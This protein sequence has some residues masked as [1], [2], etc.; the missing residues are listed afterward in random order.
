[1]AS[2]KQRSASPA[3]SWDADRLAGLQ[4]DARRARSGNAVD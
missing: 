3:L 4:A 2:L 1:M